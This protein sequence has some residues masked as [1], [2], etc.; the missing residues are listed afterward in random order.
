MQY[1]IALCI[2]LPLG[3]FLTNYLLNIMS[4]TS[5]TYPNPI[6][7]LFYSVVCLIVL[8]FVLISHFGT[9]REMKYWDLPSLVKEKE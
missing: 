4:S 7:P 9:I 3:N 2:G 1:I 5:R 6:S 8:I